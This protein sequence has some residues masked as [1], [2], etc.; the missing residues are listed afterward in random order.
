VAAQAAAR[1]G[2][3]F[4]YRDRPPRSTGLQKADC[5]DCV[6]ARE[7]QDIAGI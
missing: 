2:D 3:P 1:V 6:A 7:A 4:V 5:P